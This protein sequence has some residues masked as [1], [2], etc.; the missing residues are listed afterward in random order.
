VAFWPRVCLALSLLP[1]TRPSCVDCCAGEQAA[2]PGGVDAAVDAQRREDWRLY[3]GGPQRDA[4]QRLV[5][6]YIECECLPAFVV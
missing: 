3:G 6:P 2:K 1:V 5:L 4:E